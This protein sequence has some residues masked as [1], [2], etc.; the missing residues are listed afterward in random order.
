MSDQIK[1][2][3]AT[4]LGASAPAFPLKQ[5]LMMTSSLALPLIM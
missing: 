1:T 5:L 4:T 3:D 2:L